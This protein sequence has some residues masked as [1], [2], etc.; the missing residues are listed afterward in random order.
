MTSSDDDGGQ[1]LSGQPLMK[2]T[3]EISHQRD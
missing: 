1:R 2:V 3:F